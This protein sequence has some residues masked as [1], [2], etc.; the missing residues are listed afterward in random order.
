MWLAANINPAWLW[1]Y[2][3][4]YRV[5]WPGVESPLLSQQATGSNLHRARA[6][7]V[8]CTVS[9]AVKKRIFHIHT[10]TVTPVFATP[11]TA[12]PTNAAP[13]TATP[14][15]SYPHTAPLPFHCLSPAEKGLTGTKLGCGEGGCGACTVMVSHWEGG[16]IE[17]RAVNA[18]LCPLYAVDGMHVVT[19]E[20]AGCD[21]HRGCG[22]W[23][24]HVAVVKGVGLGECGGRGLWHTHVANVTGVGFGKR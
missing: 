11:T 13:T 19:V 16:G 17:H 23:H 2:R 24:T 8:L 22:P 12:T 18:C 14:T 10:A 7:P 9:A 4:S 1:H 21:E 15:T 20:G 3:V 6:R 5:S